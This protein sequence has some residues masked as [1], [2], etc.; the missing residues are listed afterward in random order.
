MKII[1]HTIDEYIE[2]LGSDLA[3]YGGGSLA[4]LSGVFSVSLFKMVAEIT[5]KKKGYEY[6][7]Q[8]LEELIELSDEYLAFFKNAVEEDSI[9]YGI[10]MDSFKLPK[11]NEQQI[12]YRKN[13][14]RE[15]YKNA[16][17]IPF[18]I[19]Q[20]G[21]EFL[22]FLEEISNFSSSYIIGDIYASTLQMRSCILCSFVNVK[23]NIG[24]IKDDNFV[25]DI[26]YKM[27]K[28]EDETLKSTEKILKI[29]DDKMRL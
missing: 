7:V 11:D 4:A 2:K 16:T 17:N 21:Y 25:R 13:K 18:S 5:K 23:L 29:V 22:T 15:A 10:V 20:K 19:A 6:T 27:K 3:N 12:E 1:N 9:A 26:V 14:I 28:I 24:S 8:R